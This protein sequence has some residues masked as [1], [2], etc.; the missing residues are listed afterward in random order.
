MGNRGESILNLMFGT[1]S[2]IAGVVIWGIAINSQLSHTVEK[3]LGPAGAPIAALRQ[4]T[5]QVYDRS[6]EEN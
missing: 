3:M 1:A 6:G 4:V 5:N 2:V